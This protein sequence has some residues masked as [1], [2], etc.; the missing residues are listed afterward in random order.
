[1]TKYCIITTTCDKVETANKIID[2]LLQ[3]RLVACCQMT[4]IESRYWW[5]DEIVKEPEFL[6]QMKAK[7]DLFKEIEK[8]ILNIHDYETCEILSYN[9]EEGNEKYL[10]W[11]EEEI[12]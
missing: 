3:K 12:K 9:I 2:T 8:E 6:I 11:M 10:K 1:M 5:K 7:K 4:K